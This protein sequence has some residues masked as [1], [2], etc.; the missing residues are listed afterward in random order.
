M[1]RKKES[2]QEFEAG[3]LGLIDQRLAALELQR[4]RVHLL[5]VTGG[6]RFMCWLQYDAQVGELRRL[7]RHIAP[8]GAVGDE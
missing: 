7:R 8:A 5:D 4:R 1:K 2:H 3:I 6:Y